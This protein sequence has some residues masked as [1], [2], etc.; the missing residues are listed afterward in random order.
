MEI[1]LDNVEFFLTKYTFIKTFLLSIVLAIVF[2]ILKLGAYSS[3]NKRKIDTTEKIFLKKKIHQYLI[4]ALLFFLFLV[5]FSHLQVFFVSLLA[6]T[7]AIVLAFKEVIMCFT[8]GILAR[9]SNVF[10]EGHRIEID[11]VRGFVI[12]R[13]LLTTKILEIGPEQNSQQTTGDIIIIPNSMM[14]NHTIKNESYFKGY[15][16]KS[17][18]FSIKNLSELDKIEEALIGKGIALCENYLSK[19]KD[20]IS[21]F[22]KKEGIV[23]PSVEPRTK[24]LLEE[25]KVSILLK[26]PVENSRI[27]EIEQELNRFYLTFLKS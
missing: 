13:T 19:A 10:K 27:A 8:G 7:A 22:C 3:I 2:Y 1:F 15:S 24:I 6:F 16:I 26:I 11:G 17:F 21:Y 9:S 14:L 23:I 20:E 4:Y 5:W 18:V 25:D 12:E